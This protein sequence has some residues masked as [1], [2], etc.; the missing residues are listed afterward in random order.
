MHF[1]TVLFLNSF[2]ECKC[3]AVFSLSLR[4]T[5][6]SNSFLIIFFCFDDTVLYLKGYGI[7]NRVNQQTRPIF[8]QIQKHQDSPLQFENRQF[9][10]LE[11]KD[12][13][14]NF[15]RVLGEGGFGTV[16]YGCLK[17]GIEVAVKMR[18][19]SASQGPREFLS[20][21]IESNAFFHIS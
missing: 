13:T 15:N 8:N 14:N 2:L 5:Y 11:L 18:S 20:E 9:T 1:T 19:Q 16:Y 3:Y 6:K 10:Y 4:C 12:I 21:V 7:G 17:D